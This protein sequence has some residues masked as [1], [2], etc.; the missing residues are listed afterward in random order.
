MPPV[1]LNVCDS[2]ALRDPVR[3]KAEELIIDTSGDPRKPSTVYWDG[4]LQMTDASLN[5]GIALVE[6]RDGAYLGLQLL[7]D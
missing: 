4:E 3:L 7:G 6:H 1:L 2:L 5:A